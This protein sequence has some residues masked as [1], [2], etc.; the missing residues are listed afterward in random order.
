[1]TMFLLKE[2]DS[3]DL[4]RFHRL[5]LISIDMEIS[6]RVLLRYCKSLGNLKTLHL[7]DQVSSSHLRGILE[8]L[9][10][11]QDLSFYIDRSNKWGL[12]ACHRDTRNS[13]TMIFDF[14]AS[15]RRLE[16]LRIKGH[17]SARNEA[18]SLASIKSLK[19][20]DCSFANPEFV[21]YLT[22]LLSQEPA[23]HV[24]TWLG[25]ICD[26]SG[27]DSKLQGSA[28]PSHFRLQHRPELRV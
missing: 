27:G 8:Q 17:I 12:F 2:L 16:V 25:Y 10:H 14:L 24:A 26:V 6:P 28:L 21:I 3:V 11:L 1:M 18:K 19:S 4:G 22:D 9:P 5:E 13:L 15:E 7:S 20:L 23:H